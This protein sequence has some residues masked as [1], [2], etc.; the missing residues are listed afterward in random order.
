[1]PA[2]EPNDHA[3]KSRGQHAK[4]YVAL[5]LLLALT[6]ALLAPQE[7]LADVTVTPARRI[8]TL[9]LGAVRRAQRVTPSEIIPVIDIERQGDD[10]GLAAELGQE[11]IGRRASRAALTGEQLH[12]HWPRHCRAGHAKH[13]RRGGT[14]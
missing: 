12:H 6:S 14:G 3:G 7:A 13:G 10:A 2:S 5:S 9:A 4:Y 1:M 8:V 11:G